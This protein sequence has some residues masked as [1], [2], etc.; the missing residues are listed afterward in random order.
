M[1]TILTHKFK[2]KNATSV[3]RLFHD[4]DDKGNLKHHV[5]LFIARNRAWGNGDTPEDPNTLVS[6]Q[7]E[8]DVYTQQVNELTDK[9]DLVELRKYMKENANIA[10]YDGILKAYNRYMTRWRN[11]RDQVLKNPNIS[12]AEKRRLFNNMLEQRQ[13]TLEGIADVSAG[14]KGVK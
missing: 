14:I 4:V 3:R 5:Y 7:D 1:P 11:S 13:K 10:E 8:M 12:N 9:N 2:Y 6:L